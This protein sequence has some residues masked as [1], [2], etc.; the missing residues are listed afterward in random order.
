[1]F[2]R[3]IS[4]FFTYSKKNLLNDPWQCCT[5]PSVWKVSI[6]AQIIPSWT[7]F[8]TLLKKFQRDK[9]SGPKTANMFTQQD[10]SDS[11][12]FFFQNKKNRTLF[13]HVKSKWLELQN[14]DCARFV[15]KL[16]KISW[17]TQ[18]LDA[19]SNLHLY[20]RVCPSVRQSIRPLVTNELKQ[21]KSAV[22]DQRYYQFE[23]ERILWPWIRPCFDCPLL[24]MRGNRWMYRALRS[25]CRQRI[26]L[27]G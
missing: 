11:T 12:E 22:F 15:K 23:R 16:P 17:P 3:N 18:L 4:F 27:Y 26:G 7:H 14:R 13:Y 8:E 21:C 19:F 5:A 9:Q 2:C 24:V 20:K 25:K 1:M 10:R 6:C